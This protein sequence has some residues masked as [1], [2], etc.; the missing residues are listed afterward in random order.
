MTVLIKE[1]KKRDH[2]QLQCIDLNYNKAQMRR[3][4]EKKKGCLTQI[5]MSE[6]L[7]PSKD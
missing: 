1:V 2:C 3:R 7:D 5:V 4:K 6:L